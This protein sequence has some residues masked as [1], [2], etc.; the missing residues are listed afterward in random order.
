MMIVPAPTTRLLAWFVQEAVPGA[1]PISWGEATQGLTYL[2]I[3]RAL[4]TLVAL[5]VLDPASTELG[6]A[7]VCSSRPGGVAW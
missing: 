5:G 4:Q 7:L 2:E 3:K 1:D 6:N